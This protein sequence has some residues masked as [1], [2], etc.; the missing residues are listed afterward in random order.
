M[1]DRIALGVQISEQLA[2]TT[3]FP[4]RA[5][6]AKVLCINYR[7]LAVWENGREM[8]CLIVPPK[9]DG[10]YCCFEFRDVS[11]NDP[12]QGIIRKMNTSYELVNQSFT[13]LHQDVE[14]NNLADMKKD[15]LLLLVHL[16]TFTKVLQGRELISDSLSASIESI[17]HVCGQIKSTIADDCENPEAVTT[18]KKLLEVLA[19]LIDKSLERDDIFDLFMY[20][21]R[22]YQISLA[23]TQLFVQNILEVSGKSLQFDIEYNSEQKKAQD[24]MRANFDLLHLYTGRFYT[25]RRSRYAN[26]RTLLETLTEFVPIA[27]KFHGVPNPLLDMQDGKCIFDSIKAEYQLF[28][29]AEMCDVHTNFMGNEINPYEA[30][31]DPENPDT[32]EYSRMYFGLCGD[33]NDMCSGNSEPRIHIVPL[34]KA[35]QQLRQWQYTCD[36]AAAIMINIF[37]VYSANA[38]LRK[39]YK[40]CSF[41]SKPSDVMIGIKNVQ[42]LETFAISSDSQDGTYSLADYDLVLAARSFAQQPNKGKAIR[43]LN[44]L[45]SDLVRNIREYA[46][47]L[48][49]VVGEDI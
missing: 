32:Y 49:N 17:K 47:R 12:N 26:R 36:I 3:G 5:G 37:T 7:P 29:N 16:N 8:Y 24:L 48:F 27:M 44:V 42:S 22:A 10:G 11:S 46:V 43:E 9:E 31:F 21:E 13:K 40:R 41:F 23:D 2:D 18:I 14:V 30:E 45:P 39:E 19:H 1:S 38:G 20:L 6:I 33:I 25:K 28:A 15:A 34:M 4:L 35:G